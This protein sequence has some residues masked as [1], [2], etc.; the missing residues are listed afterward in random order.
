MKATYFKD[1]IEWQLTTTLES[2][3][4]GSEVKGEIKVKNHSNQTINL[5]TPGLG[6]TYTDIKKVQAR[7]VLKPSVIEQID[8]TSLEGGQE[9]S[10]AFCLKL[11]ENC[12]VTDKKSSYY[13]SFG[14][15]SIESHLQLNI[16]PLEV[17]T[18][19]ISLFETFFRFKVKEI[20]GV[21]TGVEY[22][23]TPPT[24]RDMANVEH[25][26]LEMQMK[27][28][29]LTMIFKFSVK[30]LDM[31]GVTTKMS[32]ENVKETLTLNPREYSFGRGMINQ[33]QLLKS[34]ESVL[35]KIKSNVF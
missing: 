18:K 31:S 35:G 12:P 20:K 10:H 29:V 22:K 28:E 2:W 32:K 16:V 24:S 27:D 23:L 5:E 34:I 9:I 21:K 15:N 1:N 7:E 25:L 30:K 33:D 19:I 17:F 3:V 8:L 13:L 26:L 14:Q 4:Q 6:L 11:P